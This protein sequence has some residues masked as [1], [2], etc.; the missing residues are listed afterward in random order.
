M[1][2]QLKVISGNVKVLSDSKLKVFVVSPSPL[3]T[4]LKTSSVYGLS[5][6]SNEWAESVGINPE[7]LSYTWELST[8]SVPVF[9]VIPELTSAFADLSPY[10]ETEPANAKVTASYQTQSYSTITY[11]PL[12]SFADLPDGLQLWLDASDS[13]TFKLKGNGFFSTPL[14]ALQDSTLTI[15]NGNVAGITLN[16]IGTPALSSNPSFFADE[17]WYFNTTSYL[18]STPSQDF[19]FEYEDFTI[20]FWFNSKDVSYASQKGLFQ[21]SNVAGGLSTSFTEGVF[22]MFGYPHAGSISFNIAGDSINSSGGVVSTNTW[23]HVAFVRKNGNAKIYLNGTSVASGVLDGNCT[24]TYMALG[25]MYDTN[26]LYNGFLSNFKVVK[27]KALYTSNF[28]V[29]STPLLGVSG[30]NDVT[31]GAWLDKSPNALSAIQSNSNFKPTIS[32]SA[33]NGLSAVMFD[34]IDDCFNLSQSIALSALSATCFFVYTR[35]LT[36]IISASLGNNTDVANYGTITSYMQY[37]TDNKIHGFSDV[38]SSSKTLTGAIVGAISKGSSLF[39]SQSGDFV[40]QADFPNFWVNIGGPVNSVGTYGPSRHQGA[41]A[42]ISYING[43]MTET[44]IKAV[45]KSLMTK[46]NIS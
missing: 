31:I 17:S 2:P 7:L 1:A 15:N 20:E 28:S 4:V 46:W 38:S 45:G 22:G 32:L 8:A 23:Y 29:P 24:G 34:G 16:S 37:S 11:V 43:P 33:I 42:E 27:G 36:G 25:G 10:M 40:K 5:A 13:S 39:L 35:P 12:F 3:A 18:S 14:L 30:L 21:S 41:I 9:T 44:Q 6:N 19:A 26:Y